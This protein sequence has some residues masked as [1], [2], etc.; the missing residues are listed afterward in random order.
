[1][2]KS[3]PRLVLKNWSKFFSLFLFPIWLCF[4]VYLKQTKCQL[5]PKQCFFV[6]NCRNVKTRF[7]KRHL[8][9][10]FL[11][12]RKRNRNKKNHKMEKR[13]KNLYNSVFK[14]VIKT[15][16]NYTWIFS[17][18]CLTIVVSGRETHGIFVRTICFGS[19]IVGPK[20]SNSRKTMKI[21]VSAEMA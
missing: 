19:K 13:P 9:F 16:K 12:C 7:S 21:V 14:V 4:L 10:V 3:G 2:L 17:K 8:H 5:G 18:K 11:C 15:E 1:M 20:Q 6:Q